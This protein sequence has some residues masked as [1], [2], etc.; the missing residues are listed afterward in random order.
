MSELRE[1]EMSLLQERSK[2]SDKIMARSRAMLEESNQI[3]KRI[4]EDKK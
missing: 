2:Q 3:I 1:Q 4:W